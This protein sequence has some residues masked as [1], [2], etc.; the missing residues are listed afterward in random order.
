[1]RVII[2]HIL[3]FNFILLHKKY[4]F[5]IHLQSNDIFFMDNRKSS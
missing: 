3:N 4:K 5:I 2:H 1:M